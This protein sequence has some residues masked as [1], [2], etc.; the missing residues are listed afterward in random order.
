MNSSSSDRR[1]VLAYARMSV[2]SICA[3]LTPFLRA[4]MRYLISSA[5]FSSRSAH[6]ITPVRK[7]V[8]HSAAARVPVQIR[9]AGFSLSVFA[10][11][12]AHGLWEARCRGGTG[13]VWG[14]YRQSLKRRLL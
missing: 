5:N 11:R 7:A 13:G 12:A 9:Q 8:Q 1:L 6:E 4:M 10:A 14:L 2:E 3:S